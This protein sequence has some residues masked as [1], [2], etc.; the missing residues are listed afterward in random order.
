MTVAQIAMLADQT[1]VVIARKAV[2]RLPGKRRVAKIDGGRE[3]LNIREGIPSPRL[4][5]GEASSLA[6]E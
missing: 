4:D 3:I 5:W 6:Q 2:G 1:L